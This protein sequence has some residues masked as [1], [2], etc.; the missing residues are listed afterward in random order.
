M[1]SLND[2]YRCISQTSN[3]KSTIVLVQLN[4]NHEV[5]KGHFPEK[6]VAPGAA[7]T[8]MVTDEVL[9]LSREKCILTFKQIKFLAVIDPNKVQEIELIFRFSQR[10]GTH[11]FTCVGQ[12]AEVNYFKVNGIFG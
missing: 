11:Y 1:A 2:F 10:D 3:E 4:A 9:K 5:Y 8:Q 12:A 7:L 6:P